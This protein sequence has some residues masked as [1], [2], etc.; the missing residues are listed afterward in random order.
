MKCGFGILLACNTFKFSSLWHL[1][2]NYSYP[3]SV[4]NHLGFGGNYTVYLETYW[5]ILTCSKYTQTKPKLQEPNFHHGVPG[6]ISWNI[7]HLTRDP[8]VAVSFFPLEKTEPN[9]KRYRTKYELW[10]NFKW[11]QS[12]HVYCGD[13]LSSISAHVGLPSGYLLYKS[14]S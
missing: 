3:K 12:S 13:R 9:S 10:P 2:K 14:S 7:I 8:I 1:K 6:N 11:R 5:N 4:M